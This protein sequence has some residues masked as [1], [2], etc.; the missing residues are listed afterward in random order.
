MIVISD[1]TSAS[2]RGH[3]APYFLAQKNGR[4]EQ[5]IFS[6]EV[7]TSAAEARSLMR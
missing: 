5:I 2:V 1:T 3:V 4:M 7:I 6:D